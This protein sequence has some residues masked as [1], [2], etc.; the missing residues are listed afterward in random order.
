MV[1]PA[2]DVKANGG[3]YSILFWVR[4]SGE[5]SLD[6]SGQFLPHMNFYESV[7]PADF[8][9]SLHASHK[10]LGADFPFFVTFSTCGDT[11][12]KE[13]RTYNKGPL[14][15]EDWTLVSMVRTNTTSPTKFS[16]GFD[17]VSYDEPG[18]GNGEFPYCMVNAS[19]PI[20]SALDF[21]FDM[22]VSP[23]VLVPWAMQLS[24]VQK[25]YYFH[26]GA[27]ARR[28]R[29][30][31]RAPGGELQ[32]DLT[33]FLFFYGEEVACELGG[34][35]DSRRTVLVEN[36]LKILK[37]SRNSPRRAWRSPLG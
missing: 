9:L 34:V 12:Y 17:Y 2:A 27:R 28:Q 36:R 14:P 16:A 10:G 4:K 31:F 7:T 35:R 8:T 32:L 5:S 22:L 18:V 11:E 30:E 37:F 6:A 13:V 20:I 33:D 24:D 25:Y 29:V 23:I 21:N 1:N 26:K 15:Q 3:D 19:N